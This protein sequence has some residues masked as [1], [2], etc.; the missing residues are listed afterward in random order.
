MNSTQA[1]SLWWRVPSITAKPC[2][3]ERQDRAQPLSARRNKMPRQLRDKRHL[4]F[5]M[6]DDQMIDRRHILCHEGVR[7]SSAAVRRFAA[8]GIKRNN[9][10]HELSVFRKDVAG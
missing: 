9:G 7:L 3:G 10:C 1:A 2:P 5:H 8:R 6:L 4:A